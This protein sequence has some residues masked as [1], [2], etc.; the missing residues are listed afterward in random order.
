M[1]HMPR[2]NSLPIAG[3]E[4]EYF[5]MGSALHHQTTLVPKNM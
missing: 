1:T 4:P 3:F 2:A 5:D